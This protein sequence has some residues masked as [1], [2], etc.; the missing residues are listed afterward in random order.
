M[1]HS[2]EDRV[3]AC[4]QENVRLRKQIARQ[5]MF[6]V[7]V[8]LLV[9]GGGAFA[10]SSL[11][12][13][14]FDSI[15]AKEVVVVDN[16]GVVRAR[17]GGDLPNAVMAGGH[18][19]NRGSK[20]AGFIIYDEEGIERGGYATLDNGSN[21]MLTLDSKHKMAAIL[22]AGPSINQASA[23]TLIT[24]ASAIELRS[25]TDGSRLTVTDPKVGITLQQPNI[26]ALSTTT[27]TDYK[28]LATKYPGEKYCQKRFAD[29]TC[30]ACFKTE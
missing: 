27:C 25:D 5:N 3:R 28:E 23:L 29:S 18:V 8:L 16:K 10:G 2:I 19:A 17:M 12:N 11:K 1:L 15:K 6:W 22:V 24:Q 13:A 7:S 21:A 30:N 4:E 9:A 14:I 20:A 26:A